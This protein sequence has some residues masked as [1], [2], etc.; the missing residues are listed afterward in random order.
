MACGN[1]F[2]NYRRRG[3]GYGRRN[4]Y[5]PGYPGYPAPFAAP[6]S[7]GNGFNSCGCKKHETFVDYMPVIV[8]YT[9]T[10]MNYNV[11]GVPDPIGAPVPYG[12]AGAAVAEDILD[13]GVINGSN[14]RP[15]RCGCGR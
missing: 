12:V 14:R 8:D 1:L 3:C 15:G 9:V 10:P 7:N 11:I 5:Y 2:N 6:V 13:D 4:N